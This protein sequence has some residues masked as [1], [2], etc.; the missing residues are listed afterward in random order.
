LPAGAITPDAA[1]LLVT[2]MGFVAASALPTATLMVNSLTANGRSVRL[3][4]D[5]GSEMRRML[6]AL[7]GVLGLTGVSVLALVALTVPTPWQLPSFL[8]Q[9][10]IRSHIGQAVALASIFFTLD[11][12][13]V[14]PRS[15]FRCLGFKLDIAVE[16]ARQK[17]ADNAPKPGEMS[18]SFKTKPGFG[19]VRSL[20]EVRSR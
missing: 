8:G 13:R 9:W 10:A 7:F 15:F 14:I 1:K 12:T 2:F 17:T 3:L 11:A 5:L 6:R 4:L 18:G 16:E 19:A 20:D